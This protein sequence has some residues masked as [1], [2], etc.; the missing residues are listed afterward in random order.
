MSPHFEVCGLKIPNG[1][2]GG[3]EWRGVAHRRCAAHLAGGASDK[4]G[5]AGKS[6]A[7]TASSAMVGYRKKRGGGEAGGEERK[8]E[9]K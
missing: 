9:G 5:K 8:G 4:T 6:R 3:G 7:S 2:E 1:S